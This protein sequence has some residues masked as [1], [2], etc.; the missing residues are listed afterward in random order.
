MKKQA[1]A[2][3]MPQNTASPDAKLPDWTDKLDGIIKGINQMFDHYYQLTGKTPSGPGQPSAGVPMSFSEAR[4]IK[5][6][7]MAGKQPP[8]G[9][10]SVDYFEEFLKG[11]IKSTDTLKALGFGDKAIGEVIYELPFSLDQANDF[12]KQLQQK[13]FGGE[14]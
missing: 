1:F 8:K 7:E 11:L 14:K 3:I 6:L 2:D 9:S 10:V 5:K 13:H 12:L 4:E